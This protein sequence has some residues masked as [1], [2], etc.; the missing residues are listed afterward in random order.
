[1]T[2]AIIGSE[3]A[4]GILDGRPAVAPCALSSNSA[5][6]EFLR[7]LA[8]HRSAFGMR[9]ELHHVPGRLR[10]KADALKQNALRLHALCAELA[11]VRGVRAATSNR[12]TGSIIV[13]YDISVLP[14]GAVFAAL[15]EC[16]LATDED[17]GA[18]LPSWAEHMAAKGFEWFLEKLAIALIA[19]VV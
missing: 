16:R 14:P 7:I 15:Q 4:P 11:S 13:D 9:T 18:G 6:T 1:M 19:A 17:D 5:E 2:F 8:R 3:R 12:L 10:L